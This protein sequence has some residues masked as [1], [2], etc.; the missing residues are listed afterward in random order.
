MPDVFTEI[1]AEVE[2][3]GIEMERMRRAA[4]DESAK[5]GVLRTENERLRE[6]LSTMNECVRIYLQ[7]RDAETPARPGWLEEEVVATDAVLNDLESP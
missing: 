4:A 2:R 1:R 3:R 5:N 7:M 6:R